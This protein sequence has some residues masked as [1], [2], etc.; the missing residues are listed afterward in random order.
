MTARHPVFDHAGWM[1]RALSLLALRLRHEVALHRAL[2][3]D[4][5][6][7]GFAG[8]L[9]DGEEA[10]AM[11][12]ALAGRLQAS[13]TAE[14][15]SRIERWEAEA[16]G[17]R[18]A[19]GSVWSRL[20]EAFSLGEPE[21][22][23]I[24]LAAAPAIDPRYGRVYGF[25]GDDLSRRHLTPALALRLLGRHAMDLRHLRRL[26]EP[27]A[28]LIRHALIT[29]GR[30]RPL[31][32]APLRLPEDMV[33][34][35]LG[36]QLPLPGA[37]VG[38]PAP[39]P[40]ATGGPRP[41]DLDGR[42]PAAA[43]RD[44]AGQG[45]GVLPAETRSV[46]A[47][48]DPRAE[49]GRLGRQA[50]LHGLMLALVE[51]EPLTLGERRSLVSAVT[52][53][54]A[55]ASRDLAGWHEAGL[56]GGAVAGEAARQARA[57]T[58]LAEPLAQPFT[59]DDLVLV[60]R[61]AAALKELAEMAGAIGTVLGDWSLGRVFGK[62]P[63]VTALFKGPSGTGKTAAAQAVA[64]RLGLPLFRV[65]LAGLVSKYIGETEKHLDRLF[66]AAEGFD[67]VLLFDEADAVFGKRSEVQD[68]HDHYRNL[69]TAYL[70]QRLESHSG[71]SILTT[72]LQ[73]NID[74][75][76]LRRIDMV[77]EFPAP[78]P[79]ERRRLWQRFALTRAP[80]G[81][82]D[83]AVLAG[84]ELTGGEI[85]NCCLTVAYRAAARG[86]GIGM[87]EMMR[88]IASE[89]VKKGKPVRRSDFGDWYGAL[90]GGG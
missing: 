82:I 59:L 86:T 79:E 27:S 21:L 88:A 37:P 17:A 48:P 5:G 65:N 50:G 75:A 16:S 9:L 76:F 32:E 30:E 46:L 44:L 66:T 29:L 18:Q 28:P 60:P 42:S 85:R 34:R 38:E 52:P 31:A 51:T 49:V 7:E 6:R 69:G 56:D 67:L 58:G 36:T 47:A 80:L 87:E 23:L 68:A 72:N 39:G 63:G 57:L 8:L 33:D 10:E 71:L 12:I 84:H 43:L 24:L 89:L 70:L 35:L 25:L 73:E 3:G 4:G 13:G 55:L 77:V 45:R 61:G 41:L 19:P 11:L 53:A 2:R 1:E 22:D 81:E 62:T 83:W 26:L 64:A 54:M 78:G 90:K 15:L 20:H 14:P 40:V 74:E